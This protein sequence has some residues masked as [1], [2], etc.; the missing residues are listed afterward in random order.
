MRQHLVVG[1]RRWWLALL[2]ALV[3]VAAC[4][5]PAE[6]GGTAAVDPGVELDGTTTVQPGAPEAPVDPPPWEQSAEPLPP[7]PPDTYAPGAPPTTQGH[8]PASEPA[9][10]GWGFDAA[11]PPGAFAAALLRPAPRPA[12]RLDVLVQAGAEPR[13][14][15]LDHVAAVLRRETGKAVEVRTAA[16][17]S[18]ERAWT[19]ARIR[20]VADSVA[21][22]QPDGVAAIR[23]LYLRGEFTEHERAIGVAVRGDV[24]A[25]FTELVRAAGSVVVG[26]G[27]IEKAVSV[28]EVGHL[29]GL[30][31]IFADTGRADPE[32]PGHSP[33]RGSVMYWAVETNQVADILTGGPPTDFD[34]ADRADLAAIR[35]G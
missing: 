18:E 10:A 9:P 23:L 3:V 20:Q 12:L 2:T 17:P 27:Q 15:T 14:A 32:H 19:G 4:A 5:A 24:A 6:E 16:V 7:P 11:G 35:A 26:H 28:H 1:T 8:P 33:N 13:P 29:L 31:D 25:V 22:P 34:A 21:G 30:V